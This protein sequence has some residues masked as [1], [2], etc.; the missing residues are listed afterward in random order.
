MLFQSP[1]FMFH[2]RRYRHLV[3][4]GERLLKRSIS[5]V[6]EINSYFVTLRTINYFPR[7]SSYSLKQHLFVEQREKENETEREQGLSYDYWIKREFSEFPLVISAH[8]YIYCRY[9]EEAL[10]LCFNF[11]ILAAY[12]FAYLSFRQDALVSGEKRIVCQFP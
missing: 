3:K 11:D 4:V 1:T 12:I 5:F 9:I 10:I 8:S 7:I 2:F 6:S